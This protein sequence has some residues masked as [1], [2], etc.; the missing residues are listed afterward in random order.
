MAGYPIK[1]FSHPCVWDV[2]GCLRWSLDD[3]MN[4]SY[5]ILL[6]RAQ[7]SALCVEFVNHQLLLKMKLQSKIKFKKKKKKTMYA[8]VVVF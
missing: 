8:N 4:L 1:R 6:G 2:L 5:L 3:F 7:Y